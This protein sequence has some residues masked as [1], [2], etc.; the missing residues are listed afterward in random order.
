MIT[1]PYDQRNQADYLEITRRIEAALELIRND[2]TISATQKS[3]ADLARCCRGT[4]H[5]RKVP[6]ECLKEIK[7]KRA[8]EKS[9]PK[10]S[11]I[12]SAHRLSVDI[13]LRD[14]RNLEEQLDKSRSEAAIWVNKYLGLEREFG[15]LRR[16]ADALLQGKV[17]LERQ[18]E[19][20]LREKKCK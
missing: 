5:H 13:H 18:V 1:A 2:S 6:L 10:L 15:K 8:L 14:K 20:L 19:K 11:R 3:L 9:K 12:T 17:L 16:L 4:L 7:R